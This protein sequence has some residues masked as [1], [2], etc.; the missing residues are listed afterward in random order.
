MM[1]CEMRNTAM[2][3]RAG[4]LAL[5]AALLALLPLAAGCGRGHGSAPPAEEAVIPHVTTV[6]PVEQTLTRKIEQPGYLRPYEQT[7]VF[8]KISGFV[9]A[10][11]VDIG[12]RV[13]KDQVLVKL[14]MP[15]VVQ[16]LKVREA[17]VR[18]ADADLIQSR[19][20]VLA[21][22]A[23]VDAA[24]AKIKEADAAIARAEADVQRWHKETI[25]A[26]NLIGK[27]VYDEQTRDEMHNQLG[28]SKAALDEARARASSARAALAEMS[29]RWH[30]AEADVQVAEARLEVA[31]ADC[32]QWKA[33]L[34]YSELR[35]PFDG[36]V[37]L[38]SVH[39][40]HFLQPANSGTTTT[41]ADPLLV[42]MRTDIMRVTVQ[43]PEYDAPLVRDGDPAFVRLQAL[44]GSEIAGTVTRTSVSFDNKT[45]TLRVE[46]HLKNPKGQLH[47]GMYANVT[48]VCRQ[49]NALTLPPTA[50]LSDIL[51]NKDQPYC[52]LVENGKARKTL[53]ELGVRGEEGV[54]VLHKLGAGGKWEDFTGSEAVVVSNPG[55]LLNGQA[56]EVQAAETK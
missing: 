2:F 36:V 55:A 40:G 17:R 31:R 21:A 53:L 27:G 20:M 46:V 25:R 16:D 32:A 18:Q 14:M 9:E 50:I 41:T 34:D 22:K 56:V 44:P 7:P 45:R 11:H 4:R 38:R 33:W 49:A 30:K 6:S 24:E 8:T 28:A 3:S 26:N 5:A 35:A 39:T 19:Q 52:F 48:I 1:R 12:D 13:K 43:V 47:P 42:L 37:T 54:Q 10:V 15:E 29:A 51:A 23:A